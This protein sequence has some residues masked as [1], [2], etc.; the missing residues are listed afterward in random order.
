MWISNPL[1]SPYFGPAGGVVGLLLGIGLIG[2][3]I[4]SGR[5]GG[6]DSRTLFDRWRVWAVIALIY[7]PAVL[8]G[9]LPTTVLV[10][11]LSAQGLKEYATL[12]GLPAGAKRALIAAGVLT[13]AVALASPA[14]LVALPA[15]L[16][17]AAALGPVLRHGPDRPARHLAFAALGWGYLAWLPAHF[18]LLRQSGDTG[19]GWLIA[20]GLATA[21]AD[22]GAFVAG[23]SFGRRRLAPALSPNKT[24][25]GA[26]GGLIG[27]LVAVG[28]LV[29]CLPLGAG[30]GVALAV[31]LVVGVGSLWGDLF[32]SALKREFGV[33]DAGAWL[34]GF[35]GLLDRVDSL[36]FVVPL[37]YY[38]LLL[39]GG[40]RWPF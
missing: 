10:A 2:V 20:A 28:A 22:V 26:A 5:E 7:L 4:A 36:V 13:A 9:G 19:P 27:A 30:L 32:E 16:L 24:W 6:R 18:I 33:K 37:V 39:L 31:G 17:I 11:A 34:P 25:E 35:G 21:V 12:V 23:R 15:L 29:A 14:L 40:V 1:A 8:S 38:T 3:W